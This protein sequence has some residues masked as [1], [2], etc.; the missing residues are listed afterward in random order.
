M[1]ARYAPLSAQ[2]KMPSITW[3]RPQARKLNGLAT[4]P[5][6]LQVKRAHAR[7]SACALAAAVLVAP[8]AA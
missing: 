7:H 8:T 5:P 3:Q 2:H 1:F 6:A 4:S